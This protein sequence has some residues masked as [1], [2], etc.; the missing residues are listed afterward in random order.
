MSIPSKSVGASW[1]WRTVSQG[2]TAVLLD[3]VQMREGRALPKFLAHFHKCIFGQNKESISSKM[4]IIWTLNCF[5]GCIYIVYYIEYIV[6]LVLN[7]QIL[8]FDVGKKLYKLSKLGGGGGGKRTAVFSQ[9]T[10][11]YNYKSY[12]NSASKCRPIFSLKPHPNK[13]Q[14]LDQTSAMQCLFKTID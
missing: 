12:S 2:K 8:N 10:F 14:N 11:P 9:E 1:D 5:L 13:L 3:F 7:F 4:P 6:F